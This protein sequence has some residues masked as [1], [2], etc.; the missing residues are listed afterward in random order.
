MSGSEGLGFKFNV[1]PV[2]DDVYV[3][4]ANAAAVSF[5]C[6]NAAGDTYTLTEAKDAAGTSAAVLPTIT[7]FHVS[8]TVG[9]VWAE[10]TQTAASTIVPTASQD[11]AVVTVTGPELSDTFTHVKL[12]STGSGT[13]FAILH[14]LYVQRA[15]ANLPALV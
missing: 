15:P 9:A 2:A 14:D 11:V 8:A 12:A 7:R 5:V 6:V 1:L 10:V 4:L 3:S 13:V